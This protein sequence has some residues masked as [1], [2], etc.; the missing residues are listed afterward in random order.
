M[1]EDTD[2]IAVVLSNYELSAIM[3]VMPRIRELVFASE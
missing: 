3:P 2:T 1:Y